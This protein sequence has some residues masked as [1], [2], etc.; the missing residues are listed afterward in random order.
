MHSTADSALV[1]V[2]TGTAAVLDFSRKMLQSLKRQTD[3]VLVVPCQTFH[4]STVA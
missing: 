2:A 4:R 1:A 3:A